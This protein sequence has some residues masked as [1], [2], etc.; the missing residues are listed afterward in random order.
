PLALEP[1]SLYQPW[2]QIDRVVGERRARLALQA[3]G[4]RL[5]VGVG[6]GDI[7]PEHVHQGDA[8]NLRK[9]S[10]Q[11]VEGD[12]AAARCKCVEVD[13]LARPARGPAGR[14]VL[15]ELGR[16]EIRLRKVVAVGSGPGR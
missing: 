7:T 1:R 3:F 5:R 16:P 15:Q 11:W 12:R 14:L 6:Q 9:A 4:H 2:G 13:R 10:A 8:L